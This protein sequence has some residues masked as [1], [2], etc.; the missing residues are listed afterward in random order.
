MSGCTG[1]S[2]TKHVTQAAVNDTPFDQTMRKA[3]SLYNHMAFRDAYDLYLQQLDARETQVDE[4]K[5][6]DLLN[7][8]CMTSELAG[9]KADQT[10]WLEQLIDLASQTGNDYY[11]SLGLLAM[12][13]RIYGEG[14]KQLG[15]K[16]AS[17]A[18]DLMSKTDREDTDH[19]TH[20]QMIILAGLYGDM[21]DYEN[22]LKT[23]ERNVLLTQKGTRWGEWPQQAIDQRMALAKMALT[24]ARLGNFR[25]ADSAY[26]AW[27]AIEYEG[28]HARD[29]FIVDYLRK[30]GRYQETIPIYDAL[31][32]RVRA[33]G[34]TLGEMM[35]TAKWGLA[36]VY[37]KTGNYRQAAE[38]YGQVLEI[39]DT[40]K[41]RQARNSAQELAAAYHA[42][43]QQLA[44]EQEH[45]ENTRNRLIIIIV[46]ILLFGVIGYSHNIQ[47]QKR[48][49]SMKNHSLAA[50][51]SEAM[52]YKEKY[53]QEKARS[54]LHAATLISNSQKPDAA[55]DLNTL[56]DEQLF[57]YI[58]DVI[59]SERLFLDSKFERQI[60]MDRFQLS[61]DRV[62]AIFSKGSQYAKLTDYTY[63]LRLE[64]ST[65]LLS[66]HPDMSITQVATESGFSSYNYF[67]KCFRKRFGMTPTEFRLS[68]PRG[69]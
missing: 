11:H 29:Y 66:S 62:G 33:Q 9:H 69:T 15:I 32:Q 1:S 36:D 50:Q 16:Y 2:D 58:N 51:I 7:S 43:E 65:L 10:K 13:K 31:I 8:L 39:N 56:S 27:K 49:I 14:D 63:E 64:Y 3:D 38:L 18:I 25:R 61:K 42:Q 30:R 35:N 34:D 37:K 26:D 59:V 5:R 17:D 55:P 54:A 60:I 53:H 67:R 24:L 20:S 48:L 22:A 46:F 68:T 47:K 23:D 45:A 44:L 6:L 41:R 28:N 12:G 4:E 40:L 57:Q 19:L 21:K 52:I